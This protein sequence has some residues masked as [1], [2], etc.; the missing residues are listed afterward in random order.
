GLVLSEARPGTNVTGILT[1]VDGL[2][3]KQV[4]IARDLMP[5]AN[6]IAVLV[7][8]NDPATIRQRNEVEAAAATVGAKLLVG[9]IRGTDDIDPAFQKFA[10]ER[11]HVVIVPGDA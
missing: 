10:R 9:E 11:A 4:E 6:T 5:A 1:R 8:V 3:G 2:P 7:T